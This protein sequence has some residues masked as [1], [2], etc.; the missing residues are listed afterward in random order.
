MWDSE[1][2]VPYAY[3]GNQWVGYD[4]AESIKLKVIKS[5]L[6]FLFYSF[7]RFRRNMPNSMD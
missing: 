4:N 3:K 5:H 2:Q 6:A 1:Q 7:V